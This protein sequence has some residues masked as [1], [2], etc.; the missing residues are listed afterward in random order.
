[1]KEFLVKIQKIKA[2]CIVQSNGKVLLLRSD[3]V[4]DRDH[5][6]QAGYFGVPSFTISFG[7]DPYV[8]LQEM[9]KDYC[10]QT[11][12]N[13]SML[14]VKQYMSD[15]NA[16]QTFEVVY[17]AKSVTKIQSEDLCNTFL[18]VHK[19]ELDAYMFPTEKK[20]LEKYL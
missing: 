9:L 14:D 20:R 2:T 1:M 10:E 5:R 6:P 7:E 19:N 13:L 18:F 15:D 3:Q 4:V 16:T 17:T 11:I 12:D 8:I